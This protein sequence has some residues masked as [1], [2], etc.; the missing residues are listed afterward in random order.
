LIR[1]VAPMWADMQHF[2]RCAA[3]GPDFP[4]D[5]AKEYV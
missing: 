5:S 4:F 1:A 2:K 3:A